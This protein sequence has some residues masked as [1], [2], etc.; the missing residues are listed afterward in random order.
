MLQR[1]FIIAQVFPETSWT[2]LAKA[3]E[4]CAEGARARDDF[5][6]TYDRPVQEFLSVI[7]HDREKARDLSQEFFRKLSASGAIFEHATHERGRFRDFLK[8]AL[9]NHAADYYRR[10][11]AEGRQ[12]HP[13]QEGAER[14]ELLH[15]SKLP[16]AEAAFHQAWV[17]VVL[18]QALKRV[19]AVCLKRNQ[20]VHFE[21]FRAR[22]LCGSEAV[23]SWHELGAP[24]GMDEK[25]A[26]DR[27]ETVARHFRSVLR[28]MLRNEIRLSGHPGR[29]PD[30]AIDDEIRALLFPLK[31]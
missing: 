17:K 9:R 25:T 16:E 13:D 20:D 26:R 28:Q 29:I 19:R 6:K 2:L 30:E 27:A 15:F 12:V 11:R 31:R 18:G 8:Q 23:P 7:V 21:L 24:F 1:R 4:Q 5:A 10:E 14:W 3:R 22:Y